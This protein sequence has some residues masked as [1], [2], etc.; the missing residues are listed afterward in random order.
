MYGGSTNDRHFGD[1][2]IFSNLTSIWREYE[3]QSPSPRSPMIFTDINNQYILLYGGANFQTET[4]FGDAYIFY[5]G[6]WKILSISNAPSGLIEAQSAVCG[7]NAYLFG[8]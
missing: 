2:Y 4:I 5:Q 8:G 1:T 3:G 6:Q 7:D